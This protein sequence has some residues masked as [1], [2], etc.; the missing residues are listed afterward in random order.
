MLYIL[1]ELFFSVNGKFLRILKML[2]TCSFYFRNPLEF[3]TILLENLNPKIHRMIFR[4]LRNNF[5]CT[6]IFFYLDILSVYNLAHFDRIVF[7]NTSCC[8]LN[9]W[10]LLQAIKILKKYIFSFFFFSNFIW[11]I[12]VILLIIFM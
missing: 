11:K 12:I 2:D 6:R 1:N 8:C 3:W 9:N 4:H 7:S 5:C 10:C